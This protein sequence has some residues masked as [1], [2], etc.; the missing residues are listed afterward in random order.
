MKQHA[1]ATA[2]NRESIREVLA[3]V[4]PA[5]GVVL[6]LA[7]GSGEHSIY[8][9]EQ[10]P[11]L[12]WQPS[13]VDDTA[14]ASIR[15]WRAQAALANLREPLRIDVTED[16]WP[17]D[18]ADAITCINMVHISP[19]QATLGV[20]AGAARLGADL[21]YTYGPYRFDG[22]F[23][24]PSNA[25]FDRSLRGRN[26]SWGVRDVRDLEAVG[27]EHGYALSEVIA[28]PANNHSLIF[29]R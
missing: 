11:A 4:L 22:E 10:F 25:E 26:P 9:A 14:L 20:F 16:P 19:W 8:F 12:T 28:M 5:Q 21:V 24:A 2:R 13:D 15:A 18:R 27:R 1:P 23:T 29:R 3:R 6:E 17:I 7:A